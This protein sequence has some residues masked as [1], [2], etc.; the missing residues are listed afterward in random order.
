MWVQTCNDLICLCGRL[1][2][3]LLFFPPGEVILGGLH[4]KLSFISRLAHICWNSWSP[5][6][7]PVLIYLYKLMCLRSLWRMNA[8]VSFYALCAAFWCAVYRLT[9]H[10]S[11]LRIF[12]SMSLRPILVR[13]FVQLGFPKEYSIFRTV[14]RF[15]IQ[16][17]DNS[18][19]MCIQK[20]I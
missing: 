19:K 11:D 17:R 9:L 15:R 3:L 2:Q 1:W 4:L 16:L 13:V 8:S 12:V 10:S 18:M 14:T 6:C 5:M 7:C 20:N